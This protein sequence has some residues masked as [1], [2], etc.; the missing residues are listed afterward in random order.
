MTIG[1]D[2]LVAALKN[3]GVEYIFGLPGEE[4]VDVIESFRRS[5]IR[6]VLTRHE[7]AAA[8]MAAT[9]TIYSTAV[10]DLGDG[11]IVVVHPDFGDRYFRTSVWDL[12]SETH[13]ISQKRTAGIRRLMRLS[14][15][16][17]RT[18]FRKG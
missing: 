9:Q 11:P 6:L 7:Q 1:A 8:F 17:G 15:S 16:A 3:E 5:G 4:N 2:L 13:T 12:H 14:G 18:Q 10:L